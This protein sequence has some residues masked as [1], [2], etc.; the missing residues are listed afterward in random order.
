LS[1]ALIV[2]RSFA[3][4][5]YTDRTSSWSVNTTRM[6]LTAEIGTVKRLATIMQCISGVSTQWHVIRPR[7]TCK[8]SN[9]TWLCGLYCDAVSRQTTKP[10]I[11]SVIRHRQNPSDSAWTFF[12]GVNVILPMTRFLFSV[13]HLRVSW[14]GAPSLA[15]RRV[16]NLLVRLLLGL[17][18]AVTIVSKPLRTD[19]HILLSTLRLIQP[20]GPG[21]H[22]YIP[23]EQIVEVEVEVEVK[24]RPISRPVRSCVRHQTGTRDQFF[25]VLEI[26][27]RQLRVCYLIEP[28][29][30]RGRVCNLLLSLYYGRQSVD[31]FVL[32][33]GSPLGPM[34]R[35]YLYPFFS[36]N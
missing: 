11:L 12:I 13:W 10:A 16:C 25:F 15:R 1:T 20:G 18:R 33:S 31:Q 22:I 8:Q 23:Q 4:H 3:L 28:S 6:H 24:L 27:F 36:D 9:L 29:L 7:S 2:N 26:F 34:T 30:T 19:D 14:R 17:A 5:R 35:F 21:P 32:V